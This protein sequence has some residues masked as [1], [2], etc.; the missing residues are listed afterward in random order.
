MTENVAYETSMGQF[1][2]DLARAQIQI[3][4]NTAIKDIHFVPEGACDWAYVWMVTWNDGLHSYV[5]EYY[6]QSDEYEHYLYRA[7]AIRA[8]LQ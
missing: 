8:A 2:H 3:F 7:D 5:V 4:Y 6:Q 1:G